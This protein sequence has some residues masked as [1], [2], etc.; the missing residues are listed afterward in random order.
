MELIPN[1]KHK[2]EDGDEVL[3]T[4][5]DGMKLKE[6]EVSDE[7]IKSDS[8]NETIHKVIVVSPYAFKIGSTKKYGN[9][10]GGGI[11][12]QLKTKMTMKFKAIKD[13]MS[14]PA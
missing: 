6:G 11:I 14:L 9:Y 8:V 1:T 13:L 12:K 5:V 4:Q 2:F 7:G 3:L 10:I